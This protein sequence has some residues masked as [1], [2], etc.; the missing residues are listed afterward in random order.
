M[1]KFARVFLVGAML[2]ASPTAVYA[3]TQSNAAPAPP[4]GSY[5]RTCWEIKVIGD[6]LYA[7]CGDSN[8]AVENTQLRGYASANGRD[9]ANC[10]GAL[11][12]GSCPPARR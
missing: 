11:T 1:M 8:S 3:G 6:T 10:N 7:Q 5:Q 12:I 2:V 9:I 4:P